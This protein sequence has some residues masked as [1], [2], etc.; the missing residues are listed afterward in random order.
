MKKVV[1]KSYEEFKAMTLAA[2]RNEGTTMEANVHY[3]ENVETLVRLLTPDNRALLRTIR[4]EKPKS[5]ADL[6]RMTGRAE[7]NLFRTIEKLTAIGLVELLDENR[8]KVP[9]AKE[10]KFQIEINPYEDVDQLVRV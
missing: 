3:F 5:V 2:A 8:R 9:I 6:A 1:I 10:L 7:P 4:D